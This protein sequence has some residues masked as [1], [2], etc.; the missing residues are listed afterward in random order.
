MI[1]E[2]EAEDFAMVGPEMIGRR[3]R[4]RRTATERRLCKDIPCTGTLQGPHGVAVQSVASCHCM[5]LLLNYDMADLT[6]PCWSDDRFQFVHGVE[7]LFQLADAQF[8]AASRGTVS[9][10][11]LRVSRGV[12][13]LACVAS[14]Q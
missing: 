4:R 10:V 7:A 3:K 11:F 1:E 14:S 8:L 5:K 2:E 6:Y 12:S 9:S 13:S